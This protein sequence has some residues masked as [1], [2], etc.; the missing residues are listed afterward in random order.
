MC[1]ALKSV[2]VIE[3]PIAAEEAEW[4]LFYRRIGRTDE[5]RTVLRDP[6]WV[7]R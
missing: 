1:L 3:T 6:P 2:Q 7:V 4:P 5:C